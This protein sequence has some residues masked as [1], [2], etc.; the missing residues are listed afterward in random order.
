MTL[1]K[2][3]AHAGVAVDT[4][5]KVLRDDPTVR[6]YIRERVLKSVK[7][8][9]YHPNL[10]ARALR[11]SNLQLVPISV[12]ELGEFYYGELASQISRQLVNIGLEPALCFN[13]QHLIKMSQSFS[14]SASILVC[15]TDYDT[16]HK[17]SRRQKV[18]TID[19]SLP[20]MPSVGNVAI[21]F[22]TI[23]THVGKSL[24]SRGRRRIAVVSGHYLRRV[25]RGWPE[26]KI[27]A[28]FKLL[29][30][31]GIDTVGGDHHHVFRT[32]QDM[33]TWIDSHPGSIDAAVCENDLEAA[34]VVGELAARGLK[35]PDDILVVGCDANSKLAGMWSVKLDTKKIA[36]LA[37]TILKQLL[38]DKIPR[39]T[40]EYMPELLDEFDQTVPLQ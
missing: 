30:E 20:P 1:G 4:A 8:L 12:L 29:D 27:P 14:T 36:T 26:H 10:V 18:V 6:P 21:D 31:S 16:L 22:N 40:V 17:L 38:D 5:R 24:L 13:P 25:E 34:R 37:V 19:S 33:A 3:A 2:V 7:E 11:G 32:A 28:L 9:D 39:K 23:Y 35:T 15:G